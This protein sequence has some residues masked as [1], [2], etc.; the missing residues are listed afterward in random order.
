MEV[1]NLKGNGQLRVGT[2]E[3]DAPHLGKTLTFVLPLIGLP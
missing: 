2:T 1:T 3:L